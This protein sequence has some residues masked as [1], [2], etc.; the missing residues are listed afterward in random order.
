MPETNGN[1]DTARADVMQL[2]RSW[3]NETERQW[4]TFFDQVMVMVDDE[5]LRKARLQ[6]LAEI[7]REFR[8][9]A[10]ISRLQG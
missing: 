9:I 2:W 6:L 7:R 1:T 8:E 3:L 10:D 5:H 4:N